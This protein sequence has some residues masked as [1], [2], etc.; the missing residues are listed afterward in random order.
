MNKFLAIIKAE[1]QRQLTY[2]VDFWGFRIGNL[3]EIIS[4]VVIWSAIFRNATIVNGYTY[5]E[6]MTYIIIGWLFLFIS[7]NYGLEGKVSYQIHTGTLSNF[8]TKPISYLRHTAVLSFGRVSIALMS[9]ILMQLIVVIIFSSHLIMLA[10]PSRLSIILAMVLISYFVRL[11]FAIIVGLIS[12]WT[13]EVYGIQHMFTV[14]VKFLSG[15][16]FP[17]SLLPAILYKASLATPFVYSF[18]FPMQIY[19]GKINLIEGIFGLMVQL[20]WLLAMYV[21]IKII[22]KFGLKKYESVGI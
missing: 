21:I 22:W 14:A 15:A 10:D 9:A 8:I 5:D 12:F 20:L 18:Y 13:V 4:Q 6:M 3:F 11:F 2:R 17:L 1:W 19:L 7:S 16:Y